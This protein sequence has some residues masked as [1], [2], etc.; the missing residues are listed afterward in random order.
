MNHFIYTLSLVFLFVSTSIAQTL[1]LTQ[2]WHLKGTQIAYT[3]MNAFNQT[4]VKDVW[5]YNSDS[6]SW[7]VYSPDSDVVT[8][9]TTKHVSISPLSSLSSNDGFWLDLN[10]SCS[11][12]ML[13]TNNSQT[14]Q[15]SKGWQLRG[16]SIGF[17]S[18]NNFNKPYIDIVWTY[19]DSLWSA[20]SPDLS[21]AALLNANSTYGNLTVINP[22]DGFWLRANTDGNLTTINENFI[23][24]SDGNFSTIN[25]LATNS[26]QDIWNLSFQVQLQ[27][28]SNLQIAVL[29]T[30]ENGAY[31]QIVYDGLTINNSTITPPNKLLIHG[32]NSTAT[33]GEVEY[34]A[35]W[36]QSSIREDSISLNDNIL[37]LKLGEIMNKQTVVTTS[38][39]TAQSAYSIQIVINGIDFTNSKQIIMGDFTYDKNY[40]YLNSLNNAIEG[41]INIQ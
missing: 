26:V 2:G 8:N 9:W 40:S 23:S 7:S 21:V 27:N 22:N 29:I 39:F 28:I 31:G 30:K 41:R 38:S 16:S 25:K 24:I 20:Y 36:T 15:L 37:T 3:D 11:I 12:E 4:C 5:R 33:E 14:I 13:D 18:M 19:S 17:T 32:K 35:S 34:T 1:T 10:A 6:S